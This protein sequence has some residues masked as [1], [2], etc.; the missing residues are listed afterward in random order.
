MSSSIHR[1]DRVTRLGT[2]RVMQSISQMEV[3]SF[4]DTESQD[5]GGEIVQV[6]TIS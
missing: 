1:I 4:S 3:P 6:L 5:M 2:D